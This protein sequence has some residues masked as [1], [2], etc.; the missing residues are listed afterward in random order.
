MN[1]FMPSFSFLLSSPF[2]TV[3]QPSLSPPLPLVLFLSSLTP[4]PFPAS[5]SLSRSLF[6][7]DKCFLQSLQHCIGILLSIQSR[8]R[9]QYLLPATTQQSDTG[10]TERG[11][12][13]AQRIKGTVKYER[14]TG[15]KAETD[16]IDRHG[17]P[18]VTSFAVLQ[19]L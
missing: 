17:G 8:A 14:Q 5:T 1:I 9:Q 16:R 18:A 13:R 12:E 15:R 10:H 2:L 19:G 4:S 6:Q 3:D 7:K 11:G